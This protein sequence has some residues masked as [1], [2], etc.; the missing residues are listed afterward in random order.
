M[1]PRLN[2]VPSGLLSSIAHDLV[3]SPFK[4][5]VKVSLPP[6]LRGDEDFEE[7]IRI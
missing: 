5:E 2:W 1:R 7:S 4:K 3:F 6:D